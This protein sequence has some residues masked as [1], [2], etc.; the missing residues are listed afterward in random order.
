MKLFW[1]SKEAKT[2]PNFI[3]YLGIYSLGN[4]ELKVQ[5]QSHLQSAV[6]AKYHADC[7][8]AENNKQIGMIL[9]AGTDLKKIEAL[10]PK[11]QPYGWAVAT[12]NT[13][14]YLTLRTIDELKN[15]ENIVF[16]GIYSEDLDLLES[17]YNL[18]Q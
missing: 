6:F 9:W 13:P 11:K 14:V 8:N 10:T 7:L 17:I 15:F 5:G 18:N 3:D 12:L 16:E 1:I 2:K 4:L